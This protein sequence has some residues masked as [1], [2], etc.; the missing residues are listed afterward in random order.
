MR[1]NTNYEPYLFFSLN[2]KSG[3][4]HSGLSERHLYNYR[5]S[6]AN[7]DHDGFTTFD[8]HNQYTTDMLFEIS[9][10]FYNRQDFLSHI[11]DIYNF[12]LRDPR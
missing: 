2:L 10:N 6:L 5:T 11:L 8:Y 12:I 9:P 4:E 3:E 7:F 1:L